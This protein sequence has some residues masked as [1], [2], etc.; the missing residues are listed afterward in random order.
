M[1]GIWSKRRGF[2]WILA[3][4]TSGIEQQRQLEGLLGQRFIDLRWRPGNREE[5]AYRAAHNN[6]Y[7][8]EIR[9]NLAVDVL[10]LLCRAEQAV[11]SHSHELSERDLRWIA[12][13]ADAT[14]ILRT[15]VHQDRQGHILSL[16]EPEVGT[17]L[18]QGFTRIVGGLL[19]LGLTD[20]QPYIRRLAYDSIPSMRVKLAAKLRE[21]SPERSIYYHLEHLELL[22]A[23]RNNN[24]IWEL[25]MTL[26]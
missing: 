8:E 23:V 2:D 22:N 26:P 15:P 5:M 1:K 14:A 24:G 25:A 6:P 19:W 16:P 18:A 13:T 20:W 3:T 9:Q 10:S 21:Q 4:T 7:L 12:K 11:N 17:E